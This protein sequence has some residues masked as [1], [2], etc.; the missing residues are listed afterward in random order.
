MNI[1]SL[2]YFGI[3][4]L[5]ISFFSFFNIIYSY[6]FNLLNNLSSYIFTFSITLIIGLF[7]ILFKKY[8]YEKINLFE[9]ILIVLTGYLILPATIS[10]PY[11]L[12]IDS[13]GLINCYFEAISGFTSTGF[14]IFND[15]QQLDQTLILWRSSSQWIGGLYFLFSILLLIDLFDE[16]LKR[17]LTNYIS[18]NSSEIFKQVFKIIIIYLFMTILIF[19]LL[20]FVNLRSYEAYNYS[21][22]IISSGGFMPNNNFDIIFGSDISKIILSISMLFSFFSLFFIFNLIF[23]KKKNINYLSEDINILIYLLI[24]IALSF[25]FFNYD[26]NFLNV[27]VSISSSVSNIGISFEQVPKNLFFVF[28]LLVILGGS[29]FS[30]SSGLRVIKVLTLIKFSLNNLLSH[31]KPNQIY[32]NKLSI[33]KISANTSDINKYFFAIIIFIIS[34]FLISI[35]LTISDL[36]FES[37]FKLGILTIMNTVNSEMYNLGDLNFYN[38]N[39]ISKISLIIFMIIGRIELL[40]VIILLKKFLFKN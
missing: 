12:N 35:L 36:D 3:F 30:T 34:L 17:S 21:L 31:S 20:K 25:I 2:K 1:F 10:L 7:F 39:I 38:F 29:F 22:S 24:V 15:L 19:V 5:I 16:N 4:F 6:Y 18:L 26:N 8:K 40:S 9:R 27:L 32:S 28:L 33:N 23:F 14:T 13:L 11:Y 37:S